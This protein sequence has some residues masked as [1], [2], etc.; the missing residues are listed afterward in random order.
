MPNRQALNAPASTA[1]RVNA[2]PDIDTDPSNSEEGWREIAR[3]TDRYLV[4]ILLIGT[5]GVSL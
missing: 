3:N 4:V 5:S 2:S 1:N